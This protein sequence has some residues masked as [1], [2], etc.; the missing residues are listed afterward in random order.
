L[1]ECYFKK[2]MAKKNPKNKS[3]KPFTKEDLGLMLHKYINPVYEKVDKLE[4]DVKGLKH[5]V[6]TVERIQLR[7][8]N[9]LIDNIKLLH[10]RNDA[11]DKKLIDH[12]R[13][14]ASLEEPEL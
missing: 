12:G 6:D 10:D 13:R 8:E 11:H 2:D 3:D 1:G 9:K 14:I 7:M 4:T 5:Q